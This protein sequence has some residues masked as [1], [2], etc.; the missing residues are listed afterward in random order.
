MDVNFDVVFTTYQANASLQPAYRM[1]IVEDV[2]NLPFVIRQQ[3]AEVQLSRKEVRPNLEHG[4]Q[5]REAVYFFRGVGATD[6][7]IGTPSIFPEEV[8]SSYPPGYRP[9][10]GGDWTNSDDEQAEV[11]VL[12]APEQSVRTNQALPTTP[13]LNDSSEHTRFPQAPRRNR[14]REVS[15][16]FSFEGRTWDF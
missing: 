13:L 4:Q 9:P 12:G 3:F 6:L 14:M 8:T 16:I 11:L 15:R 10:L 7:E 5:E 2:G 1:Q